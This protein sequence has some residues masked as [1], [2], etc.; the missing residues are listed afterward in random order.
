[1]FGR[2]PQNIREEIGQT[3]SKNT[4]LNAGRKS[5]LEKLKKYLENL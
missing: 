5:K 3:G 4:R 1:M 2:H